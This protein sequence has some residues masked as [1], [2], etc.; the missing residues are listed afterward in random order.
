MT[1]AAALFYPAGEEREFRSP[2]R[3]VIGFENNPLGT[4][5]QTFLDKESETAD[6]D[7]LPFQV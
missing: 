7:I 2:E 4:A 3:F 5:I 1:A 6:G